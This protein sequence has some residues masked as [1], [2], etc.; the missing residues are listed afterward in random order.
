MTRN[1]RY[2]RLEEDYTALLNLADISRFIEVAPQATKPGWPP[3]RYHITYT[4]RGFESI[5]SEGVPMVSERHEVSLYLSLDYPYKAPY[6]RWLTPIWHP[7]IEHEEPY[8]VCIDERKNW[9]GAKALEELVI[10]MGEMVQYRRYHAAWAPPYPVDVEVAR[11]VR[12][13]A[14]PK[15][16]VG[17]NKP[18]DDRP[19]VE[20]I[21]I[22]QNLHSKVVKCVR[23]GANHEIDTRLAV[24]EQSLCESCHTQ[25]S[26]DD[27]VVLGRP[28]PLPAPPPSTDEDI[29]EDQIMLG[30]PRH[31]A[32]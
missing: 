8:H 4:C 20:P 7:N 22:I 19:L 21:E 27:M 14:E 28:A 10:F 23:C 31:T 24:R 25:A 13:Y 5:D 1:A 11:W 29:A 12:E 18:F 6:L 16:I 32:S 26:E 9:W 30:S 2:R 17:P 15:G 3:E